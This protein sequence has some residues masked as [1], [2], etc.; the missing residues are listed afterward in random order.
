MKY[1]KSDKGYFIIVAKGGMKEQMSE[2]EGEKEQMNDPLSQYSTKD[3][4]VSFSEAGFES[5]EVE[6]KE[7][8][9]PG[10]ESAETFSVE[11]T[12]NKL[13]F[14]VSGKDKY[15]GVIV[16]NS[17]KVVK[18]V[19][20]LS[21]MPGKELSKHLHMALM[22]EYSKNGECMITDILESMSED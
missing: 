9:I 13:V 14:V 1:G 4:G 8:Y 20:E 18:K 2:Q 17:N 12:S 16:D 19:D 21:G 11:G 10:E 5:G 22:S 6:G 3:K 15:D 7:A